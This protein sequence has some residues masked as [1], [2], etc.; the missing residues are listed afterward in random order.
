[1]PLSFELELTARCNNHCRHCYVDLPADDERAR[2]AELT[3]DEVLALG[4]EA[5]D[6]GALWC[7]LTG[8]E[9]LLRNDFADIYLG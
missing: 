3:T 9:P 8:G 5:V 1:M 7:L 4:R 2:A 6:L